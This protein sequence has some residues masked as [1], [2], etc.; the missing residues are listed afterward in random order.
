MASEST[1]KPVFLGW[2]RPLLPLAAEWL[3][4]A[5]PAR[6]QWD[7]SQVTIVLPGRRAKR[8][9]ADLL[10]QFAN[11]HGRTLEGPLIITTGGLP[12]R[13]YKPTDPIANEMEQTLAWCQVLRAAP[14]DSL[15][16]LVA[17]PPPATPI[18]PWLELAGAVRRLH[19]EL[20]S[21]HYSFGDVAAE[22]AAET[23]QE[24]PRWLLLDKLAT[25][26]EQT[27]ASV[28]RSDPYAQR[29]RAAD[30]KICQSPGDVVVIGAVD[31]NK[32]I[33]A[34]IEEIAPS[35]SILVGA[36]PEESDLFDEWG[37]VVSQA[38]ID[39]TL[40][41]DER[42]LVPA[43]DAEDQAIATSRIV[44]DWRS[45]FELDQITIGITDEAMIAPISQQLVVD[46]IDAHAE[47]GEP[48]IRSAPARLLSLVVDYIQN[49][50]FRAFSSLVRH[51]DLHAMLSADLSSN[52]AEGDAPAAS[53]N[54]LIALDRLRSEHF[55]LRTS[56]PLPTAA[57]DRELVGRLIAAVD[58]WLQPLLASDAGGE[59]RL[60]DWCD[61]V[62]TILASVYDTRRKSLR[63]VWQK[64]LGQALAAIDS[65]IDRLSSVPQQLELALP[66]GTI[67]E[68]LVA[69]IAEVRLHQ[70]SAADKIE[71]VGWL[72]LAL[73][74]S[75][76]LCVVGLNEPF[77]PE[78]V[79]ADPFLPGGLRHRLKIADNDQRY[80]RD[81]YA[82]SLMLHSRSASRLIVG[83][84]SADG[85][86]TP[87][88]RLLAA[89]SPQ[90]AATRTL[91]LLEE[92][93]PRPAVA[94][95]WTTDQSSSDLP[96][97]VPTAYD[98]PTI[99]SVTAFG[100]YLR[101]PYRFYLRHIAKLRPLDDTVVELAANQF[102][103]LIHDALEEFGKTGPKHST[104]LH[105]VEAC[106]LDVASD[107]GR[108]RY[109]EHPSAPVRLQ[110]TSALNRLKLVAQR[111]VE[112]THQG[113]QLWAAER[114][115]DV[116]DNA[117]L[118][119]DG[120]PFG[121]KGRIDRIDYHPDNDRWAVI[122]YKTHAHD[123]FKKHYKK[124]T[125]EWIDL[126][127][128]LYRHM[129]SALGIEADRDSV[130]LGYFNIGERQ[131]DV[132]V[133][134][135][136]FTPQ[137]YASADIAAA[138][139]VRGVREGRFVANPDAATNFDDYAVICQTGSIEHLFAD[140]EEDALEETQ[141]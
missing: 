137:L 31:L 59:V 26:Y 21:E 105:E 116:Q 27:L 140:Q 52:A 10:T 87:P 139:V 91:R 119:V 127:L 130:Q 120:S 107:L 4:R 132:R 40:E 42:Q 123:P 101:C 121:L 73:D 84:A 72:D 61:A 113:W 39:R 104:D 19:E 9:F 50:S 122:D 76:A 37:C 78:S 136:E 92:L 48:L 35:V 11:Q 51:A 63:G 129:L 14:S 135:A 112:R 131:A 134:I 12:E 16:P 93:P 46:G 18:A 71:L 34:M 45:Q 43:T 106:L 13:L 49:R 89:C 25:S 96:I 108:Q 95:I 128:P 15:T 110:I 102:G 126:Q 22:L 90:T 30:A 98:P 28:G 81:A 5:Y 20:A 66:S 83:R 57:A 53:G 85:S 80:A 118:M 97:P 77:V 60:A 68:M 103:N 111:Q 117:V 1:L 36:P 24:M 56:D 79:V 141:A 29:R 125:D 2:K 41:I 69:Q 7:L 115:V 17:T 114:Q 58:Q 32:S 6:D 99:L 133:N 100:D 94:S 47:L 64:R 74:T 138:D 124:T 54:W 65:A 55:P 67:A 62:H 88:S 109:G 44:S 33:R 86:P 23:P 8:Q 3:W 75:D 82:L 70:P 38:W